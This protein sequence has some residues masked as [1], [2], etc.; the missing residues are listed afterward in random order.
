VSEAIAGYEA[1]ADVLVDSFDSIDPHLVYAF[2]K[3]LLPT[4]PGRI[5]D[6][7]AGTGRDAAWF[8]EAGHAVL[9]VEPVR[10]FREAGR[11][12]HPVAG[13]EW[14]DDRLPD[15]PRLT[16]RNERFDLVLMTAV[17]HHLTPDERGRAMDPLPRLVAP[18]GRLM[19]S[20]RHGPAPASRTG[21][22]APP[23]DTVALATGAGL[24][25]VAQ[26]DTPSVSEANIAAGVTWT[27]LAFDA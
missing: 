3:D 14:L 18:G 13:L 15:L 21:F 22:P 8:V 26:R 16:A 23:E 20:L 6:I 10:G 27:W 24:K 9:A 1:E 4:R 11:R 17:W 25:L 19:L 12:L 2:V 7:G 5:V